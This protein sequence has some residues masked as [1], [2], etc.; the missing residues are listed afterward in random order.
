MPDINLSSEEESLDDIEKELSADE[1]SIIKNQQLS[2][3]TQIKLYVDAY[4]EGKEL[5]R[6]KP[7]ENLFSFIYN[8]ISPLWDKL[9][10][11]LEKTIIS[12]LFILAGS[13]F[14]I[15][16]GDSFLEIVKCVFDFFQRIF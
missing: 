7:P 3:E 4:L 10:T 14:I 9:P 12:I 2:G 13:F 1:L 8:G 6:L 16:T 15:T 5:S 11:W